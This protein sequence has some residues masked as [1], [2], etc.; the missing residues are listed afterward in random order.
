MR[1]WNQRRA[2]K[3]KFVF[4]KHE[5]NLLPLCNLF[6][7]HLNQLYPNGIKINLNLIVIYSEVDLTLLGMFLFILVPKGL[8]II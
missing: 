3:Y 2:N 8:Y 4:Y 5:T 6:F 7:F 1:N